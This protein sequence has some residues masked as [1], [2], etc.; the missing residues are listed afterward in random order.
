MA[1]NNHFV[2]YGEGEKFAASAN[3]GPMEFPARFVP[4]FNFGATL[5]PLGVPTGAMRAPRSNAFSF[6]FQSFIDEMAHAASGRDPVQFGLD[7]LAASADR[8]S[9]TT[10]S[11]PTGCAAS[12]SS[13]WPEK[14]DWASRGK[15]PMAPSWRCAAFQY[16]HRGYFARTSPTSASTRNNKVKV[17][18]VWVAA[19]IG[20]QI[21]NTSSAMNNA[22]GAVIEGMSHLMGWEITIDGGKATQTNFHQYPPVRMAQAPPEIEVHFLKTAFPPTGS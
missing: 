7:L 17:H 21:V 20:S 1:W 3:I 19:D 6:V 13:R 16:S 11:M 15:L 14:S 18:K 4:N 12:S 22:Q 10:A 5:M 9:R 8:L 2:T